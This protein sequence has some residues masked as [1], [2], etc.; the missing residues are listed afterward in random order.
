MPHSLAF[1]VTGC[2][3]PQQVETHAANADAPAATG[4][5]MPRLS[6]DDAATRQTTPLFAG[7]AAD[8]NADFD[9]LQQNV[10]A[11]TGGKRLHQAL[12]AAAAGFDYTDACLANSSSRSS[13]ICSS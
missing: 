2:V 3:S 11:R 10:T 5:P 7:G 6:G 4:A 8:P 13:R 1:V 12:R 9:E